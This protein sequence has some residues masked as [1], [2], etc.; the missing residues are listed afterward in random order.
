MRFEAAVLTATGRPLE[1]AELT[2]DEQLQAGQVLVKV[3]YSGICGSQI[4]EIDGR[5]GPDP[6]LPHLLGHEAIGVVVETGPLATSVTEGDTV[7]LHWMKGVGLEAPPA[8]YQWGDTRVNG[9]WVTTFTQMSVVSENRLTK[10]SSELDPVVLT[11]L[12]C[13]ATT[14]VGVVTTDAAVRLGDSVVVMGAGGIGL[15]VVQAARASGAVPV[16]AYDLIEARLRQAELMG[17]HGSI[18]GVGGNI[19]REILGALGGVSPDVVIE[20]TGSREVIEASIELVKHG[21]R[22]VL[23]GVPRVDDPITIDSLPLHFGAKIRGSMGGGTSPSVDIPRIVKM[24]QSRVL[25]L[26]ELPTT[27]L[28]LA[29]VNR[30]IQMLRD[31]IVGRVVLDMSDSAP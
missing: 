6:H 25:R 29:E 27:L 7:V 5:K 8:S 21:G 20:T 26:E 17:A 4:G 9:G 10:V 14:A 12:G 30:G 3:L 18:L 2:F 16:L 22:V 15:L 11:L 23:V 24:M 13:A 28:P 31:G 19:A 1:V